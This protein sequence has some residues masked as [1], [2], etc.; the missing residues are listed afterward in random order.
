MGQCTHHEGGASMTA[1][2][3]TPEPTYLDQARRREVC[4][5]WAY[6]V[7]VIAAHRLPALPPTL[8]GS[9]P[10]ALACTHGGSSWRAACVDGP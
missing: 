5:T 2:E 3:F 6:R 1:S 9:P 7:V 8:W 4:E 10:S